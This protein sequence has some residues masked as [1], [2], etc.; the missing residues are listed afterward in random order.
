MRRKSELYTH[1]IGYEKVDGTFADEAFRS[2][3][4]NPE[5]ALQEFLN[6]RMAV[7]AYVLPDDATAREKELWL[8]DH[9]S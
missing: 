8:Q 9:Q 4:K 5:E 2:T 1:V 6:S 7:H 3:S